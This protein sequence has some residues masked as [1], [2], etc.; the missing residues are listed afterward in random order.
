MWK[1]FGLSPKMVDMMS[2]EEVESFLIIVGAEAEV[3]ADQLETK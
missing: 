1:E 2:A 3:R